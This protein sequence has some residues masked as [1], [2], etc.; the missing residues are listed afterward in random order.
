LK[1]LHIQ[2]L[3]VVR[4]RAR[5]PFLQAVSFHF[6]GLGMRV[7]EGGQQKLF[8]AA[9]Q[10]LNHGL[11]NEAAAVAVLTVDLLEELVR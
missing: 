5:E 9:I 6:L 11:L 2:Q 8:S 1:F 10:L 4:L 7:L 3:A